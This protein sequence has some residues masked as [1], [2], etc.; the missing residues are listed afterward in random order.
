MQRK[1]GD[2]E[3]MLRRKPQDRNAGLKHVGMEIVGHDELAHRCLHA[4][5]C[6]RDHAE[7]QLGDGRDRP[8][9]T[10][11]ELA[12]A[13]QLPEHDVGVEQQPHVGSSSKPGL[14]GRRENAIRE[15]RGLHSV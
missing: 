3:P 12:R 7:R 5:L 9:C 10:N 8:P 13:R 4:D 15:S 14:R 6:I 1:A 11:P 2:R